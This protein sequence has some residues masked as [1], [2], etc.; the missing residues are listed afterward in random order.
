M[1]RNHFQLTLIFHPYPEVID[2]IQTNSFYDGEQSLEPKLDLTE[3]VLVVWFIV[4][5]VEEIK[6]CKQNGYKEY[7]SE[8]WNWMDLTMCFLYA[9]FF[10]FRLSGWP[11]L[12]RVFISFEAI[13]MFLRVFQIMRANVTFG[14]AHI[15]TN[16]V[17]TLHCH[18]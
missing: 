8:V 1:I 18:L 12:A 17:L 7:L 10:I 16:V 5:F 3:Y 9:L 14:S 13:P 6:E 4:V 2:W 11:I 15:N